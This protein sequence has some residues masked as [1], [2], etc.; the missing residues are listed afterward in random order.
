MLRATLWTRTTR[1]DRVD[2]GFS[3]LSVS[4]PFLSLREEDEDR[5]REIEDDTS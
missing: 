3:V 1:E 4:P 2:P 5:E